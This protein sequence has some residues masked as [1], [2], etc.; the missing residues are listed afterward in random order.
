M[1]RNG[2]RQASAVSVC[3]ASRAL[4]DLLSDDYIALGLSQVAQAVAFLNADCK[5][6]RLG[7]A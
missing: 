1:A 6:V 3:D 4:S 2:A 7:C 5:M